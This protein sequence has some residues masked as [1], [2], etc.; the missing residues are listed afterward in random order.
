[1]PSTR[2][3]MRRQRL[4]ILEKT[5]FQLRG[6]NV[7]MGWFSAGFRRGLV[8]SCWDLVLKRTVIYER[9]ILF[10]IRRQGDDLV[11]PSGLQCR[12][13]SQGSSLL[14]PAILGSFRRKGI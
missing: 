2:H 8:M 5:A 11:V 13:T 6:T 7:A 9:H 1:M 12:T 4:S 3:A 10:W 14:T